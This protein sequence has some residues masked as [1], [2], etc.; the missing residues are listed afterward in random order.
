MRVVIRCATLAAIFAG[1]C[2]LLQGHDGAMARYGP[3]WHFS[4]PLRLQ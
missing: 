3:V 1:M 2:L 4:S